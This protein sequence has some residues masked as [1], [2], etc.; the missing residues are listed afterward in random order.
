MKINNKNVQGIFKF[1]PGLNLSINDFV[2]YEDGLYICINEVTT[3][4]INT[5]DKDLVNFKP[6]LYEDEA[7]WEDFR[8]LYDTGSCDKDGIITSKVLSKVL[9]KLNFGIDSDGIITEEVM[10]SFIS[11]GLGEFTSGNIN[12]LDQLILNSE[13]TELNNLT[14]K[15]D[16]TLPG[17]LITEQPKID[18]V[19]NDE[20]EFKSVLLKQY[21]YRESREDEV[22]G[23]VVYRIQEIVDHYFGINFYRY[24]KLSE[25]SDEGDI[26]G[27]KQ[28]NIS[29][30]Y[31][32]KLTSFMEYLRKKTTEITGFNFISIDFKDPYITGDEKQYSVDLKNSKFVTVIVSGRVEKDV[33][34]V[35]ESH[36]MT[37]SVDGKVY[38]FPNTEI[39]V[40]CSNNSVVLNT[41]GSDVNIVDVYARRTN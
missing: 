28:S 39:T 29:Y 6:Y 36:S 2:I 41:G 1:S 31:I 23:N 16:R 24:A 14:I 11:P 25:N 18:G 4:E 38:K 27:W 13:K 7:T 5:P 3:N 10:K 40:K 26:S 20:S 17:C 22:E 8:N 32:K 30:D 34:S 33:D 9:K 19:I 35:L 21:T 37:V 15:I 12:V